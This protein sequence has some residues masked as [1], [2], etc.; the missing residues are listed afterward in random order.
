[1]AGSLALDLPRGECA[2]RDRV[3]S[4][5]RGGHSLTVPSRRIGA[6]KSILESNSQDGEEKAA[7]GQYCAFG[8]TKDGSCNRGTGPCG[9]V[10]PLPEEDRPSAIVHRDG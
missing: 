4:R 8:P 10:F 1:V 6:Y 2:G 3:T 7:R 9:L 5:L